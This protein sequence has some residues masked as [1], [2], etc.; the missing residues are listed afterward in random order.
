[1]HRGD[2]AGIW[3]EL[4]RAELRSLVESMPAALD[5]P[6]TR[7]MPDGRDL[8]GGQWQSVGFSRTNTAMSP[9]TPW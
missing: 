1:V 5:T 4:D 8:S 9:A 3:A 2:D 6:L 7:L